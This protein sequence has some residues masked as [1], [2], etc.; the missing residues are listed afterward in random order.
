M[1]S[2]YDLVAQ[3]DGRL[4]KGVDRE[5]I[6]QCAEQIPPLPQ[7]A[8]KVLKLLDHP[9]AD[10][11][12]VAEVVS[13]DTGLTSAVLKLANSAAFAQSGRVAFVEQAV[14]L[15]GFAKLR[16]T[17]I[18]TSLRGM[19]KREA[20]DRLVW[21][22][23]LATAIIA[24]RLTDSVGRQWAD[25]VFLL[26]LLHGLGQ[27]VLLANNKT[28]ALYPAVLNRIRTSAVDYVAAEMEEIGF[29]HPLIGALVASRWSFPSEV[30]QAILHY[31]DPMEGIE[32]PADRKLALVKLADLLAHAAGLGHPE[33]YPTD[34]ETIQT[35]AGWLGVPKST[36][37]ELPVLIEEAQQQFKVEAQ[38]WAA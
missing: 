25:E 19:V 34:L 37:A 22:N 20:V 12:S 6:V 24:R 21:E 7:A 30:C 23:S 35:L 17:V 32:T 4:A 11:A 16:S 8:I 10:A 5:E 26:G 36:A 13:S 15:I 3:Y 27:F 29:S 9:D 28:R 33:G 31:C 2:S 1:T 18:A 14:T 38:A